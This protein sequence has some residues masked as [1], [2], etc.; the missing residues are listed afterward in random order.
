MATTATIFVGHAHPNHS[1]INPTHLIRFT[2]NDKPTLILQPLEGGEETKII[3]PTIENTVDDIYLMIAVLILK[4]VTPSK[5]IHNRE[6][7]SLYEILD[8]QERFALYEETKK[9]IQ[10][11]ELKVVFNIL[12]D[13]HL[14]N[15]VDLIKQYPN[16]YEVTVPFMKNEYSVWTGKVTF[17]EYNK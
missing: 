6:R 1:G 12:D 3:I 8:E 7:K 5:E 17:K 15:Q 13:S 9:I 4:K 10:E 14:L 11:T 16:D 2:E